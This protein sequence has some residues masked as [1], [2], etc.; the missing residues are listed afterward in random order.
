M[1]EAGRVRNSLNNMRV[2][3]V[4]HFVILLLSFLS[5]TI[6]IQTLGVDYLGLNGIFSDVL[7]LLSMVDLGFGTS[8]A[9]S[10][11]GPLAQKEEKRLAALIHF[12]KKIFLI[13]A[14]VVTVFGIILIPFLKYF[15][16]TDSDIPHLLIYYLLAL[17]EIVISYLFV[18]RTSILTADQ[19]NY[20]AT[21]I[22]LWITVIRIFVQMISLILWRNY[23][24]YL[25]ISL[26]AQF[27]TN[28]LTNQKASRLYPFLKLDERLSKGE[29]KEIWNNIKSVFIYKVSGTLFTA[30]DNLLISIIVSTTMV[31]IYSNYLML[32]TK[33]LLIMQIIFSA[34]TASIG[35][36]LVS[37]NAQKRYEI[38]TAIQSVS[39]ILCGI[40]TSVLCVMGN[41]FI[42][43]WLGEAFVL[44]FITTVA[45][46]VNT[47]L[48]CVLQPLWT[49]RDAGGLYV[50]TKY[51]MLFG[52][53]L[54]IILSIIMGKMWGITGILFA[55]AI[56]RLVSCLLFEPRLLFPQY[57][58]RGVG[59]YYGSI[60]G[61]ALLV[62]ASIAVMGKVFSMLKVEN[63]R[64]LIQKGVGVSAICCFLFFAIYCRSDGGKIILQKLQI[65]FGRYHK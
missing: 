46:S 19:K 65:R 49:Y 25:L 63:W 41:D 39:F 51:I 29:E 20:E 9:Y 8:L 38:F 62:A 1:V 23:I 37:E 14:G 31:G 34:L 36:V 32:S 27:L 13:I 60:L 28:L 44:P 40:I 42:Y 4:Y 45:V 35:N 54:N 43:V 7:N 10:L 58:G 24:L 12:Y 55:T 47:Y 52:A 50:Q 56:A 15:I 57:F 2:G 48:S 30:T 3:F 18:Y 53:I 11:Y 59:K 16:N 17:A 26:V 64:M 5:R 6:F 21:R 33:L 61:N 22:R